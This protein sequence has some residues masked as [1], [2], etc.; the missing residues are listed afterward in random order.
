MTNEEFQMAKVGGVIWVVFFM[1]LFVVFLILQLCSI[2]VW[3]WWWVTA[4]IWIPIALGAVMNIL[5]IKPPS[6]D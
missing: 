3:S 2:I 6:P 5:G 4:P 1:L